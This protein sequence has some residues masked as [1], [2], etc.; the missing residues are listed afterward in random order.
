MKR[1]VIT[2]G[3]GSY[4]GFLTNWM[5][6]RTHRFKCA[7][8]QRSIASWNTMFFTSDTNYLFPCWGV[9]NNIWMDQ[10]R[11]WLHSPLKYVVDCD[12][13][14][15]FIHSENDY[16]CPV[17]EGISMFQA[18]QYLGVESRLCIFHGESHGLCRSGKPRNRIKRLEEIT[19]WFEKYLTPQA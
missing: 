15:L 16:R 19:H 9:E 7:V 17:S 14:T 12:T 2:V 3:G 11:Y 13:P 5:I 10:Q 8:S 18:L 1:T 6:G 4:G